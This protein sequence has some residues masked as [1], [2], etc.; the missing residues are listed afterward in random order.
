MPTLIT[1]CDTCNIVKP[2]TPPEQTDG[3]VFAGL[4]EAAADWASGGASAPSFVFDGL[5]HGVQCDNTGCGENDL[6]VKRV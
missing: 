2:E 5:S 6:C 3:E 4:V 1:I